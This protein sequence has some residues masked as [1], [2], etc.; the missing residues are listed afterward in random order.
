MTITTTFQS[1]VR[2]NVLNLLSTEITHIA[3][4]DDDTAFDEAQST[5]QSETYREA[6]LSTPS[7]IVNSISFTIL[8]DVLENNGNDIRE[9]GTFDNSVGGNMWTRNLTNLISKDSTI[10]VTIE[11]QILVETE[12]GDI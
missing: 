12:N 3:V 11:E 10:E 7:I 5:L 8:L 6:L 4:G 2:T 1:T 9:S